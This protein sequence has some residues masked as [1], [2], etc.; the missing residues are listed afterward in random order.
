LATGFQIGRDICL[1]YDDPFPAYEAYFTWQDFDPVHPN[2]EQA[3]YIWQGEEVGRGEKGFLAILAE[4]ASLPEGSRVLVYPD[5][6]ANFNALSGL[7]GPTY[8]FPFGCSVLP[9]VVVEEQKLHLIR[10][11]SSNYSDLLDAVVEG[12]KLYIIWSPFDHNGNLCPIHKDKWH[13]RPAADPRKETFGHYLTWQEY[14]GTGSPDE[15]VYVWD[16]KAL[17]RG[18]EGF[19]KV[20]ALL[21]AL[22]AKSRVLIYPDY[23]S[24]G[25]PFPRNP[26]PRRV[27]PF[28]AA[29]DLWDAFERVVEM[30]NLVI[31]FSVRDHR[32]KLDPANSP[33]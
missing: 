10:S 31:I 13:Y 22:P 12:R 26:G 24:V 25:V 18:K 3:L 30:R 27:M 28:A 19:A 16:G 9:N 17:G 1:N 14:E 29:D 2:P 20:L 8:W 11:P 33:A 4:M 6:D 32:G 23:R 5:Y 7:Q 21:D 15:A